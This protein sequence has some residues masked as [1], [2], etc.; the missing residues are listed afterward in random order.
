MWRYVVSGSLNWDILVFAKVDPGISSAE[1]LHL[2]S[3]ISRSRDRP[4]DFASSATTAPIVAPSAAAS[5]SIISVLLP[6]I[7]SRFLPAIVAG[8]NR[9]IALGGGIP[10]VPSIL[11]AASIASTETPK[12]REV[13]LAGTPRLPVTT[14]APVPFTITIAISASISVAKRS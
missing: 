8:T 4:V 1:Q 7:V 5:H 2:Q 11:L 13:D 12:V 6:T 3:F 14:S 10:I 9:P